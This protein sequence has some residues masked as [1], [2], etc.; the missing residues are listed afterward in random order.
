MGPAVQI[1]G[2]E[3]PC[4]RVGF[5]EN[6]QKNLGQTQTMVAGL[7]MDPSMHAYVKVL[8]GLRF[9]K[10][11]MEDFINSGE[12]LQELRVNDRIKICS[13]TRNEVV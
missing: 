3:A 2:E 10:M 7:S 13:S 11:L 12:S 9:R 1:V 5:S 6:V 4:R 8:K